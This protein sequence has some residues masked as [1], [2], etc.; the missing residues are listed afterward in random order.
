M[1][2]GV[3]ATPSLIK[4]QG[5]ILVP[6][7]CRAEN[8]AKLQP[9]LCSRAHSGGKSNR[10]RGSPPEME[11][12]EWENHGKS[13]KLMENHGKSWNMLPCLLTEGYRR[14]DHPMIT[15]KSEDRT[16]KLGSLYLDL[17]EQTQ[18]TSSRSNPGGHWDPD[19]VSQRTCMEQRC[20][21]QSPLE[22]LENSQHMWSLTGAQ[23][24]LQ[25][26]IHLVVSQCLSSVNPTVIFPTCLASASPVV[27]LNE[28]APPPG[29]ANSACVDCWVCNWCR[30]CMNVC[31]YIYIYICVHI[32][33]FI[34]IYICMYI[35]IIYIYTYV[36]IYN[37]VII[38]LCY[39]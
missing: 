8:S 13:W 10:A 22:T 36:Y 6:T 24:F 23:C 25:Y 38:C 11:V 26:S 20:Q 34:Y 28:T 39:R 19:L 16:S 30:L 5:E 32:Y 27:A 37:Y 15:F 3:P 4:L 21:T 29:L 18:G 35:T 33:I 14:V 7:E 12:F 2:P 17:N 31:V 9:G 1:P